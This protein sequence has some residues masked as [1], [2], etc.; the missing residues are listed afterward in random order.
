MG[1]KS[2]LCSMEE[3]DFIKREVDVLARALASLV[4]RILKLPDHPVVDIKKEIDNDYSGLMGISI[5]DTIC[6]GNDEFIDL[7]SKI[8]GCRA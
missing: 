3:K 8:K 5:G 2:I 1:R 4:G 7:L 6:L